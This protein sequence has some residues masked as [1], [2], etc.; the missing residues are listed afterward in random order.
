M[1]QKHRWGSLSCQDL[2][3]MDSRFVALVWM[4]ISIWLV[5]CS[6][7]SGE[8]SDT[9][10]NP[11]KPGYI[12]RDWPITRGNP[13]LSGSIED[14]VIQA[15]R[16][17]W[18]F[19][20]GFPISVDAAVYQGVAYIGNDMG[21][22][23][24]LN[25]KDGAEI[26]R[27]ESGD[28]IES[29]P[30]VFRNSIFFGSNNGKFFSLDRETGQENW[31]IELDDKITAGANI[32]RDPSGEETRLLVAGN[33]GMLRC[34]S[35]EDGSEIWS[36]Q[37]DNFINGTPALI[38]DEHII[39]GGCDANLH[40]LNASNGEA[41]ER[42]ETEAYI[43]SS[44][45]VYQGIGYGGN[46]ANQVF[47]FDYQDYGEL[48]TYIDRSFPFFSS[49]AVNEKFVFIGSR[50]KRLHAIDRETGEGVWAYTTQGR[51]DSSPLAFSD[52][53][54]FGSTD[55]WLYAVNQTDGQELWKIELG[56]SLIAS[57]IFASG[58]LLIGSQGGT[59][60]ALESGPRNNT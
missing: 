5:G 58:K 16:I 34:L 26:W 54:V 14:V 19:D 13:Q 44:V 33:D 7:K 43:P 57:P 55:G 42:Y 23:F 25:L 47:A 53:V 4:T 28:V 31:S 37:T 46:Y 2:E 21:Q 45:A 3:I 18:T 27:F 29:E 56:G 50:D 15:P 40:V 38:D 52:A 12:T 17:S 24:A 49:P 32:V 60:F 39:F 30:T 6:S 35:M 48:W 36:Y 59:L 22:L 51:V 1:K 9:V 10:E 11:S 20:A 8:I 41:V